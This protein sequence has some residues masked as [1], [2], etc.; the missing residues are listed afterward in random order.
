M[1]TWPYQHRSGQQAWLCAH[2][3]ACHL[4]QVWQRDGSLVSLHLAVHYCFLTSCWSQQRQ[5]SRLH[6]AQCASSRSACVCNLGLEFAGMQPQLTCLK[7]ENDAL[8][9]CRYQL[10][11]CVEA[12]KHRLLTI[13]NRSISWN[14]A[15]AMLHLPPGLREG[16]AFAA[17]T[18][19]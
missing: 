2:S 8:L 5:P 4:P 10:R 11:V 13:E 3:A 6:E 12:C 15:L 17:L 18:E 7:T 1:Y 14:T 16:D 19:V 9:C